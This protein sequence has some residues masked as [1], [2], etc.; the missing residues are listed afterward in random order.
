[1]LEFR[2]ISLKDKLKADTYFAASQEISCE[3]NFVTLLIWQLVYGTRVAFC[4]DCMLVRMLDRSGF[5]YSLPFGNFEHG[6]ELI[7]AEEEAPRFWIQEGERCD[8][9]M[10]VYGDKYDIAEVRDAFDYLYLRSDLSELSGKKYQSKRNHISAFSRAYDWRFEPISA[11]NVAAVKVCAEQWY[12]ES[13][14]HDKY[15]DA[16]RNGVHLLLDNMGELTVSGGA[17]FV[18]DRA[19]AFTLGSPINSEIF[20]IHIEKALKDFAT[21]YTVINREFARYLSG[22]TYLNREDDMGLEG[23]RRAKLSYRPLRFVKKFRCD[24]LSG[25]EREQC[26]RIYREAFGN[27][28]EFD[29]RLF[30]LFFS[31]CKYLRSDGEVAAMLFVLPCM[32][33]LDGKSYPCRYIYAAATAEKFRGRGF[34]SKLLAE[35]EGIIILKP[36]SEALIHFYA[37]RGFHEFKAYHEVGGERRLEVGADHVALANGGITDGSAFTAMIKS[38]TPLDCEGLRFA[39]TME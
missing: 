38:N 7:F 33:W 6:M 39:Y 3:V 36:A 15:L 5:V 35:Q 31:C 10:A 34:M 16:E 1:M 24:R 9:F 17:I 22:Y 8:K 23:L 25:K 21:A 30:D 20:N 18:G 4:D 14:T 29:E 26:F 32:L 27:W 12:S 37:E 19:V 2:L 13:D 28:G 11:E